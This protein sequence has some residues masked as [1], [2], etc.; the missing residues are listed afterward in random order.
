MNR[1]NFIVL[2]WLV[3][4]INSVYALKSDNKQPITITANQANVDQKKLITIFKGD[5]VII[6]GSLHVHANK[7]VATQDAL[8]NK[9]LSLDGNPVTFEQKQDNGTMIQ[10]QGNKFEFHSIDNMALLTGRAKIKD[11]KN[12]VSGDILT[13]NTQ[14]QIYSARSVMNNGVSTTGHGRVTVILDQVIQE[15][16]HG[17][18]QNA[19]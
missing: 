11:G 16:K 12:E 17:A 1:K 10:G 9:T 13:Y 4:I 6:K 15:D 7:G 8:G 18:T 14:T 5:V 19:K 2:V 3:N